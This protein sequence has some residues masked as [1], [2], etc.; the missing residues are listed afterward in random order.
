MR[1]LWL[2]PF[3]IL[4]AACASGGGA[5]IESQGEPDVESSTSVPESPS[6]VA[7]ME[8]L[9]NEIVIGK[10]PADASAVRDRDWTEGAE[11]PVVS[12]IEYGDFQ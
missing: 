12:I 8:P 4:L 10:N 5:P 9:N 1:K 3:L 2:L 7:Q 6:A 11:D